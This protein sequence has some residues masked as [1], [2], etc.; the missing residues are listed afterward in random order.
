LR[1]DHCTWPEVE[2][3]LRRDAGILLPVGSTEQHGPTGLLGTDTLTA[4]AVARGAAARLDLLVAPALPFGVAEHHMAF[5]GTL[6]LSEATFVAAVG[7]TL[8]SLARHGFRQVLVVNGHGGNAAPLKAAFAMLAGEG[9]GLR[10]QALNW[11]TGPRAQALRQALYGAREGFHATPSEIAVTLALVP[12]R[13]PAAALGEAGRA[14]SYGDA[15]DY[16]AKFPDGRMGSDPSLARSEDGA[17][18]LAAAIDDVVEAWRAFAGQPP[19]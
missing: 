12:G 15:A 19:I 9:T 10:C 7:D 5:A 6:A 16:R 17:K 11:W 3:R 13:V 2:A 8:R 1:L 4:T 18:L 14:Q